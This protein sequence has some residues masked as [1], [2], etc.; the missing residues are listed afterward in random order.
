MQSPQSS[1]DGNSREAE[2]LV[3]VPERPPRRLRWYYGFPWRPIE[4]FQ[5]YRQLDPKPDDMPDVDLDDFMVKMH[6]G[7]FAMATFSLVARWVK[8]SVMDMFDMAYW[9][10][11]AL[12]PVY[13][14]YRSDRGRA[15][16]VEVYALAWAD[17]SSEEEL[18]I[19][20][21]RFAA[22]LPKKFNIEEAER[23]LGPIGWGVLKRE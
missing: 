11:D 6:Q 22:Q 7:V 21:P 19:T 1:T 12:Q 18:D 5:K 10:S 2:R 4:I 17:A 9:D 20:A 13:D 3:S 23:V 14:K 15:A 8:A 16:W